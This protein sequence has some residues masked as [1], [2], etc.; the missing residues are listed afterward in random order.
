MRQSVGDQQPDRLAR[1]AAYRA[2]R[3]AGVDLV[4]VGMLVG[5]LA[6]LPDRRGPI[7][8]LGA[9]L[10]L[11]LVLTGITVVSVSRRRWRMLNEGIAAAAAHDACDEAPAAG[12]QR[13]CQCRA[14]IGR[15]GVDD[16]QPPIAVFQVQQPSGRVD[17]DH[18]RR[19]SWSNA[20]RHGAMNRSSFRIRG[21][22]AGQ[23]D[24]PDSRPR[25]SAGP[26]GTCGR[27][28]QPLPAAAALPVGSTQWHEACQEAAWR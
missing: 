19:S 25:R 4:M 16:G 18:R 20:V 8:A 27:G 9:S 12:Q 6:G 3:A 28:R 22:A 15:D 24:R 23:P 14:T 11:A 21:E 1:W 17:R 10:S 13:S 26:N 7:A 2:W 5:W